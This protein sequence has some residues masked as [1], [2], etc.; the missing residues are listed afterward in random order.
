MVVGTGAFVVV[1]PGVGIGGTTLPANPPRMFRIASFRIAGFDWA[2]FE[3]AKLRI[4]QSTSEAKLSCGWSKQMTARKI[5]TFDAMM[6]CFVHNQMIDWM[7]RIIRCRFIW[8]KNSL[9]DPTLCCCFLCECCNFLLSHSSLF[10]FFLG[11]KFSTQNLYWFNLTMLCLLNNLSCLHSS[12]H[13]L[14][15][16]HHTR[17]LRSHGDAERARKMWRKIAYI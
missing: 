14:T 11:E 8:E 4:S 2:G 7:I 3:I 5:P 6:I 1:G 16:S 10:R 9:L 12:S 15:L 13:A 17:T